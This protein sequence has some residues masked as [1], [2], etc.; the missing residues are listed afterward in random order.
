M[1]NFGSTGSVEL[2][3]YN[4]DTNQYDSKGEVNL[5]ALAKCLKPQDVALILDH[6]VNGVCGNP[7]GNG[8]KM[9]RMFQETHRTLQG[10]LTNLALGILAGMGEADPRYTDPRNETAVATANKVKA[11]VD[12]GTLNIQPFI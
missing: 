5:G 10:C 8:Q 12:D 7:Y 1:P 6:W 11:L 3:E 9:G 4:Y 2:R